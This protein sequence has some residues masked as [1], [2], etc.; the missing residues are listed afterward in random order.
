MRFLLSAAAKDLRRHARDPVALTLWLGIPLLIGGLITLVMSGF[1][2]A[3]P[4]AHLLVADEDGG[5]LSWLLSRAFGQAE[6]AK[7]V[8]VEET[9][10]EEGRARI[11]H[12]EATALLVIPAGFAEAVLKEEPTTLV[13]VTNP[14]QQIL[15]KMVEE[16]LNIVA[17]GVFYL[18]R[19][20]GP[21]LHELAQGPPEGRRQFTDDQ[22]ARLS[23]SFN[24][25]AERLEKYFFPPVI[26]VETTV[27]EQRGGPKVSLTQLFLPG[28]LYMA[29]VFMSE[30]LSS[31]LWRERKQGTLRRAAC[32]PAA[33]VGLLGGKLLAAALVMLGC[34]FIVLTAG[35]LY[36]GLPLAKLP[37]LLAWAVCSGLVFLLL[38]QMIQLH[39]SSQRA[40]SVLT[41]SIAMPLL[42]LGGSF[43]PFEAMPD[44][45]AA[46]GRRTPNG[47]ALEHLKTILYGQE[48]VTTLAAAFAVTFVIGAGLF[49]W[50]EW[51][52]RRVF[53]RA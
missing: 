14:A 21:E 22:I 33:M 16:S 49:V 6:S 36:L 30:G 9:S 10:R 4:T 35:M 47:W 27:D 48:Q 41:N 52:L 15:P 31:D 39:A 53:A 40:A 37:L 12:G 28:V 13:L 45:M 3:P 43:F 23:V 38:L 17:D 24:K 20:A 42:F 7:F 44:W 25:I 2:K 18:H 5:R 26:A 8:R 51:R 19:L 32:T 50:T 11:G 46:I 29:L 1:D 34:T